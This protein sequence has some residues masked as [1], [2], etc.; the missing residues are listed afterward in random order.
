[1]SILKQKP[2]VYITLI[3]IYK[4]EKSWTQFISIVAT[5]QNCTQ[6]IPL[7][8]ELRKIVLN[9]K[10]V[11]KG[12]IYSLKLKMFVLVSR[13]S[14]YFH[15]TVETLSRRQSLIKSVQAKIIHTNLSL[16]L[17]KVFGLG[18]QTGIK[19]PFAIRLVTILQNLIVIVQS[20]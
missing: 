4:V 8:S 5:T 3:L 17:S 12:F 19:L 11:N 13:C 20:K 15:V 1:M 18:K 10:F 14:C 2:P 9:I 16:L 7:D 6:S